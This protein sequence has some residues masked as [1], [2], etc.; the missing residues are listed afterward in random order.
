MKHNDFPVTYQADPIPRRIMTTQ[1]WNLNRR[2][3]L[4]RAAALAS[5][6]FLPTSL[7]AAEDRPGSKKRVLLVTGVDYPGHPWRET[8]PALVTML[9]QDPRLAVTVIEDP[10][11]LDSPS[12]HTYDTVLLHFMNWEVPAPGQ[13]ARTNLRNFVE[14]GKGLMLVHFA[15]G[16][17]LDWPEFRNLAG[18]VWDPKLRAHDP[19]GP[20]T[21]RIMDTEHPITA[22]LEDFE[23]D[24]ELYTCLAGDAP[25]RVLATA[26]SKVDHIDYPM[27]FVLNYGKG[28]V[29]HSVL[30]HD[31]KALAA[32]G[33]GDLFRRGCAWTAGLNS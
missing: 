24:D 23:I 9:H 11:L 25:I 12:V 28:R 30:G 22:G 17:W 8:A 4:A 5:V 15:C 31:A 18:R 2:R 32:P 16:A 7:P 14:A 19:R 13:A 29:F 33:V 20:F 3:F 6:P 27:A 26:R 1:P 21:V 10:H